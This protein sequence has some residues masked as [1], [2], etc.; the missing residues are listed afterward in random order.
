MNAPAAKSALSITGE[1]AIRESKKAKDQQQSLLAIATQDDE[2]IQT[3]TV[4]KTGAKT[5]Y[6]ENGIWTDSEF[7]EEAK[8]PEVKLRFAS[9]EFFDLIS[10]EKEL[11]RYFSLGEQVVVVWK[12]KIYRIVK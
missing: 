5:F 11:A 3:G 9:D 2:V 12:G 1:S 8:L 6:L 10:K 4:K 7:K